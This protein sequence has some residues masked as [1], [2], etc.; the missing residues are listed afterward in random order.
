MAFVRI[1]LMNLLFCGPLRVFFGVPAGAV[2]G[3]LFCAAGGHCAG[4]ADGAGCRGRFGC[5]SRKI[6][7]G[8]T[9]K[10]K[11]RQ[12]CRSFCG[13][14]ET[15]RWGETA[16]RAGRPPPPGRGAAAAVEDRRF[17]RG[18]NALRAEPV[19]CTDCQKRLFPFCTGFGRKSALIWQEN[20]I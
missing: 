6:R 1:L 2:F 9:G 16:R 5:G 8:M 11:G 12:K 14:G 10:R 7:T 19:P 3:F 13:R 20:M 18:R 15:F 17:R 4:G